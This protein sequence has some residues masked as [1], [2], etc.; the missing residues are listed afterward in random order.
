M[1]SMSDFHTRSVANEGIKVPLELPDGTKTDHYL[2]VRSIDSDAFRDAE[3]ESKRNALQIAS[4]DN[5]E[6]K[7]QALKDEKNALL[8]SLVI[9]W[10]FEEECTPENVKRFLEEAPQI[11]DTIDYMATRRALFF[12]KGLSSSQTTQK[13][14]SSSTKSRKVQK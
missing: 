7:N 11:A 3:T 12:G 14:S 8:V 10:T 1:T 5:P 4:I 2:M 6:E 9:D 13:R